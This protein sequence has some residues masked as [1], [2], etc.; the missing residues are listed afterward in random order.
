MRNVHKFVRPL[1]A[2]GLVLAGLVVGAAPASAT[3][4]VCGAVI[5]ENTTRGAP[6]SG[7]IEGASTA[8]A[9]P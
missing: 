2:S 8:S 3:H 6:P 7:P 5:T 1:I 9:P 4:V